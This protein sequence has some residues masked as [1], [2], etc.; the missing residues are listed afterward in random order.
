LPSQF[1]RSFFISLLL[2]IFLGGFAFVL[3]QAFAWAISVDRPYG[4]RG[5]YS[6]RKNCLNDNAD[7]AEDEIGA[8]F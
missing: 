1:L 5:H 3:V 4:G 6:V 8:V 7:Y 2:P